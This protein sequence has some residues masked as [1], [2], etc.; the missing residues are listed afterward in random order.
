MKYIKKPIKWQEGLSNERLKE[1][2]PVLSLHYQQGDYFCYTKGQ[3][4]V[5][6]LVYGT[7]CITYK[8][9]RKFNKSQ[10]ELLVEL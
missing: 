8:T 4:Y 2:I 5:F 3:S 1:L 10:H 7:F 6:C 9:F